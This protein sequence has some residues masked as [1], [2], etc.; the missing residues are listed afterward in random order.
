MPGKPLL[1]ASALLCLTVVAALAAADKSMSVQV[2]KADV[3]DTPNVFGRIVTSLAYGD[4]V[5]VEAQTGP[6]MK[7]T[8]AGA[9]G[10]I[11]G[12]ALTTKTIVM[13]AG[14]NVD[15]AASSGELAL[16]GKGFNADVEAQFKANHKDIDFKW[17][18]RMEKIVIP[19]AR[20]KAFAEAGSLTSTAQGGAR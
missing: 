16:A 19:P 2:R 6:W 1:I 11:H 5:A 13:Q 18:D 7:V 20:L 4:K 8:V 12:S 10:W 17:V 15:T 3:R 14:A 9:P